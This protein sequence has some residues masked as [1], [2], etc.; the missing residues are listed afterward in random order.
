MKINELIKQKNM[1]MY[2]LSKESGI[3]YATVNDIC[4]GKAELPKCSAETI[5]R[6]SAALGVSIETLIEPYIIKRTD[7]EL[8]KSNICHRL[9]NLGDINFIIE[10]LQSNEIREYFEKKWY[11]ECFYLLAML[12]FVSRENGVPYASE[13]D[14]IRN[15]KLK[16]VLYPESVLMAA[17][18]CKNDNLKKKSLNDAIPEFMRFNIVESEV[19]NVV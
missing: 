4:S 9:K 17:K 15:M 2:R 19:R 12:D 7:F 18:V 3:P 8:F 14:D 6:I 1:T 11:P 5:Y 10:I 16:T 13:F